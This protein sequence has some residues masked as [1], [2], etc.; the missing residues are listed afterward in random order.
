MTMEAFNSLSAE[1]ARQA[2]RACCDAA[3]WVDTVASRRPYP[4]AAAL[5]TAGM[6]AYDALSAAEIRQAVAAHPAIGARVGGGDVESR[7][8]RGEQA[9]AADADAGL[10]AAQAEANA[11]YTDRFGHVFLICATGR[12]AAEMLAEAR[13]RLNNDPETEAAEVA[14]ELREIVRLRLRKLV[15][16]E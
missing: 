13:R 3:A 9:G 16:S 6:A 1:A 8:S 14:R 12:S 11:A 2:L 4:D 7:W 5:E 15:G 10:K